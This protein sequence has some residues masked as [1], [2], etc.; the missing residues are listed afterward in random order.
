MIPFL[1][2][3]YG[4]WKHFVILGPRV[5]NTQQIPPAVLKR[6]CSMSKE[7]ALESLGFVS[8]TVHNLTNK[9]PLSPL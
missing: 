9:T 8:T 5:H 2:L 1:S 6:T 3:C 7:K 4:A